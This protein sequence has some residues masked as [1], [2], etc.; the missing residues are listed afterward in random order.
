MW[1]RRPR[2]LGPGMQSL[3]LAQLTGPASQLKC[4]KGRAIH[5]PGLAHCACI[6]EWTGQLYQKVQYLLCG[7]GL[8]CGFTRQDLPSYWLA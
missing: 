4:H 5:I 6:P 7:W 2:I 8:L 3:H 1:M